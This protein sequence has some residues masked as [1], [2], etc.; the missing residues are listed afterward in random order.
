MQSFDAAN[1][2]DFR[3]KLYCPECFAKVSQE[4]SEPRE[5][6]SVEVAGGG[7]VERRSSIGLKIF[8]VLG[9][10]LL[11][12]GVAAG[13]YYVIIQKPKPRPR[14]KVEGGDLPDVPGAVSGQKA[15][16]AKEYPPIE[17]PICNGDRSLRCPVCMEESRISRGQEIVCLG[18]ARKLVP[19]VF[20]DFP[21]FKYVAKEGNVAVLKHGDNDLRVKKGEEVLEGSGIKLS[22]FELDGVV[23]TK[24]VPVVYEDH[25]KGQHGEKKREI[26]LHKK[27]LKF[28][29]SGPIRKEVLRNQKTITCDGKWGK[30]V[31]HTEPIIIPLPSDLPGTYRV[32][33]TNPDCWNTF[34]VIVKDF[35]EIRCPIS[36]TS[37][38]VLCPQCGMVRYLVP[39]GKPVAFEC[40]G[41]DRRIRLYLWR[42]TGVTYVR[43]EGNAAIVAHEGKEH[44]VKVQQELWPKAGIKLEEFG[45]QDGKEFIKVFRVIEVKFTDYTAERQPVERSRSE[46]VT[47]ILFKGGD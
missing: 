16:R 43:R 4:A 18:C 6:R 31:Y 12:A 28:K 36:A 34:E 5:A 8:V 27:V 35:P 15:E 47:D 11:I 44:R 1:M 26:V 13:V 9:F 25:R 7:G 40:G 38:K 10:I 41:C 46:K 19:V 37:D 23:V 2:T 21:D 20:K 33:C 32:S 24:T 45:E 14:P 29:E 30:R 17:V 42:A 3:G 39:K 22:S